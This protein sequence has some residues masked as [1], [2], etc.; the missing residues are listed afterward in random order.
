[1]FTVRRG[2]PRGII[3]EKAVDIAVLHTRFAIERP[4]CPR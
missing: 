1:M 2:D 3:G 4:E